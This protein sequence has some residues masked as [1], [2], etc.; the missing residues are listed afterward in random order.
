MEEPQVVL[1]RTRMITNKSRCVW[2][3]LDVYTG[4][5]NHG[6]IV[7]KSWFRARDFNLRPVRLSV[8]YDAVDGSH[9][10]HRMSPL[11]KGCRTPC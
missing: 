7:R 11:V 5:L 1:L 9:R 8:G 6:E 10:R 4:F 3:A 2:V